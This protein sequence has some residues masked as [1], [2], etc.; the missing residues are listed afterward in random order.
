[1]TGRGFEHY[2]EPDDPSPDKE[3]DWSKVEPG[4]QASIGSIDTRYPRS[5]IP[6]I[7]KSTEWSGV[8]WRGEKVS[9]Q[10]V[11]WSKEPVENIRFEFTEFNGEKGK[12]P[13]S[14]GK[15]RFV[16]YVLTDEFGDGDGCA[17][18]KPEDFPVS[19]SPDVLDN[20]SSFDKGSETTRPVWITLEVPRDAQPG[21]Y[22]GTLKLYVDGHESQL[23]TLNLEVLP[24]V[25]PPPSEWEFHL[26]LW[27]HPYAAA[28]MHG[29]KLWSDTH[30]EVMRPLM[31]ML[32]DAGQKVITTTINEKPWGNQALDG[33]E[34]MVDWTKLSDGT[35]KYDYTVFDNWVQFMMDIGIDRQ[36]NAYSLI[37]WTSELVYYDEAKGE[38]VTEK[39]ETGSQAYVELWTPFI[40]DFRNHLEEKGWNHITNLAMDEIKGDPMESMLKVMEEVAP[41][42]GLA[43][44]DSDRGYKRFPDRIKDL[45]V[46]YAVMIDKQDLEYR[47]S[48]GYLSTF[49][50]CCREPYPNQFTF[51]PPIESTFMGWYTAANG[52]DGFIRWAY[53][54]WVKDPLHDTRFRKWPGGDTNFVY[55]GPRSSIRFER[56]IEGIQDAEK[57]RIL[58]EEFESKGD[59]NRLS[60]L[61]EMLSAFSG[62]P[63]Q[64][65]I[66]GLVNKGKRVLVE[67]SR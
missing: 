65:T 29:V 36:I 30:W 19:L 33:Y 60:R 58:R 56:L 3:A 47:R 55:P 64:D 40:R 22:Q 9:A 32:A 44:A 46:A 48:K 1:M 34:S 16:R 26:D 23:F 61:N 18:R 31:K 15:A 13:S 25:L 4:L 50:V 39:V 57:I 53:A 35:W 43:S 8:T 17:D 28:R 62:T 6:E 20:A 37:P 12:L 14:I 24:R 27:Q 11:L 45:T 21:I 63:E 51:S 7:S 42:F 5:S 10:L 66:P 49:Y 54:H 2:N 38:K 41:E 67:L 59:K 52:F